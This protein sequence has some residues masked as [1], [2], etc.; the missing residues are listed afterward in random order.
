MRYACRSSARGPIPGLWLLAS[1]LVL[2]LAAPL[3][4]QPFQPP[5]LIVSAGQSPDV[6]LAGVL[7]RRAGIQHTLNPTATSQDLAGA[8]TVALVI[9]ASLKGLGAAGVD[10]NKEKERIQAILAE[11][12]KRQI[13]VLV[14]HLG[15]E[16]RR[17]DLTDELITAFL[18]A[19][20]W[21]LV[22]ESS[23]QDGLFTRICRERRIP[24]QRVARTADG[25]EVLKA[26]FRPGS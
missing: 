23:D 17:G 18:P 21:A 26:A 5:L 9:G 12:Q 19:A 7:A 6:Q 13:P 3:G 24:L 4:G 15:G 8:R 20:R 14:L 16:Q 22:L 10:L 1:L 2:W 11:A 25:A